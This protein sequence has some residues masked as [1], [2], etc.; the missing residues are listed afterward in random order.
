MYKFVV[1]AKFFLKESLDII[2]MRIR[3]IISS[4]LVVILNSNLVI[5]STETPLHLITKIFE[6]KIR[7][8]LELS[9]QI[10][11]QSI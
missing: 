5:D 11:H 8:Q 10:I 4:F 6:I 1:G 2:P 9:Q 3:V 7:K